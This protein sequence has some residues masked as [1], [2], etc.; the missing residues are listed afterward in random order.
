MTSVINGAVDKGAIIEAEGLT[1]E[2]RVRDG[3]RRRLLTANSTASPSPACASSTRRHT[4]SR[5]Q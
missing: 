2:F 5:L 4:A 3:K 1:H